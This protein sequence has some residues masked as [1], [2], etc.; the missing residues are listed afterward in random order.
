MPDDGKPAGGTPAEGENKGGTGT[1]GGG[2]TPTIESLQAALEATNKRLEEVTTESIGRRKELAE[3]KPL[4]PLFEGLRTALGVEGDPSAIE[5]KVKEV[6]AQSQ[7]K[8]RSLLLKSEVQAAAVK[9]GIRDPGDALR[10]LDLSGVQ[11]DLDKESVDAKALTEQLADLKQKKPYLFADAPAPAGGTPKPPAGTQ[12]PGAPPAGL[13]GSVIEAW[14]A[15]S[16]SG[17]RQA[18][19]DLWAKH[20]QEIG[21]YIDS[22]RGRRN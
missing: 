9:A 17:N 15:A 20:G 7:T 3:L 2:A 18:M 10:M 14:Q 21:K 6:T 4:K 19:A 12:D 8:M 13:N 22:L 1:N 16:G 5:A 11:V